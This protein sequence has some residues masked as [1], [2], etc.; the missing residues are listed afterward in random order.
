M[1]STRSESRRRR[2][3]PHPTM[4]HTTTPVS[5]STSNI[6]TPADNVEIAAFAFGESLTPAILQQQQPTAR[7]LL[8]SPTNESDA[9]EDSLPRLSPLSST[10]LASS[11]SSLPMCASSGD[12]VRGSN[13]HDRSEYLSEVMSRQAVESTR[14]LSFVQNYVVPAA[15]FADHK[16]GQDPVILRHALLHLVALDAIMLTCFLGITSAATAGH[17]VLG[18]IA[19]TAVGVVY[20]FSF[21][22]VDVVVV[23]G[24][25]SGQIVTFKLFYLFVCSSRSSVTSMTGA[26]FCPHWVRYC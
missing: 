23:H 13:I 22:R 21:W 25:R 5:I 1:Q 9:A 12:D 8:A 18:G 17:L 7:E 16:F 26:F 24:G 20:S 15:Q 11:V 2:R 14:R 3:R 4:P 19:G 10:S 6:I